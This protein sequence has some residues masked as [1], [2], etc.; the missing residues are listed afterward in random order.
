ME[1]EETIAFTFLYSI[2]SRLVRS[3]PSPLIALLIPPESRR[4]VRPDKMV[5]RARAASGIARAASHA[6]ITRKPPV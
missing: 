6:N 4:V 3:C 1:L 2:A 5:G